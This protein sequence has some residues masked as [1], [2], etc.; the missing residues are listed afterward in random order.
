MKG[1]RRRWWWTHEGGA[2]GAEAQNLEEDWSE[3]EQLSAAQQEMQRPLERPR[4]V[5]GRGEDREIGGISRA[6]EVHQSGRQ[7]HPGDSAWKG[8]RP[9]QAL[10]TCPKVRMERT[11]SC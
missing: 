6:M 4:V 10:G 5:P 1:P 11:E 8:V 3:E 2:R 7:T 9:C